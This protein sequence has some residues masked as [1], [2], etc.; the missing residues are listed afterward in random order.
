MENEEENQYLNL[1]KKI[2]D[3]GETRETRNSITKSIFSEK[4]EKKIVK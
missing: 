1:I 3:I 4:L 2:I